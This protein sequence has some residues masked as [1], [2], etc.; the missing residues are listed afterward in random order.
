MSVCECEQEDTKRKLLG[1]IDQVTIYEHH[2]NLC[3]KLSH[4]SAFG[5]Y[6]SS[7]G[8]EG[9]V[10]HFVNDLLQDRPRSTQLGPDA[11][12]GNR[13]NNFSGHVLFYV[14]DSTQVRSMALMEDNPKAPADILSELE[15][16]RAQTYKNM[17]DPERQANLNRVIEALNKEIHRHD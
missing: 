6:N 8:R 16:S 5:Y 4:H 15:E 17:R 14:M 11:Y 13:H 1:Q 2:C 10:I 3:K 12:H 9:E 7:L